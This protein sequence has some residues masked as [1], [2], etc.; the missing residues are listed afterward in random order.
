MELRSLL[1]EKFNSLLGKWFD[2]Q[3]IPSVSALKEGNNSTKAERIWASAALSNSYWKSGCICFNSRPI[4]PFA[5]IQPIYSG[6]NRLFLGRNVFWSTGFFCNNYSHP[7]DQSNYLKAIKITEQ[8][9][10]YQSR[11]R[12]IHKTGIEVWVE[13][14][15][16]PIFGDKLRNRRCACYCIRC[17]FS[18]S[19]SAASRRTNQ[20]STRS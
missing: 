9:E 2:L 7:E 16:A 13:M 18:S 3:K 14:R 8:G 20:R 15:T 10:P 6:F 5:Y 4:G 17:D 12:V 1:V 11:F 19:L